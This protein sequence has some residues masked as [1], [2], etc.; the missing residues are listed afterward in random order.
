MM[1][2]RIVAYTYEDGRKR[3]DL[4][5]IH[6]EYY[7]EVASILRARFPVQL[8]KS[9]DG[10]WLY[11]EEYQYEDKSFLFCVDDDED[12]YFIATDKK[13]TNEDD[14]WLFEL[15]Q[16]LVKELDA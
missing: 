6:P 3:Y 13:S 1:K 11:A 2:T 4:I 5:D 15:L 12:C 9:C 14:S 7:I 10:I 16:K 8:I